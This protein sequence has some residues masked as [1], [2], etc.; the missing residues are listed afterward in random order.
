MGLQLLSRSLKF[1]IPAHLIIQLGLSLGR[2]YLALK[3]TDLFAIAIAVFTAQ[4]NPPT[5]RAKVTCHHWNSGSFILVGVGYIARAMEQL[6]RA[7]A[8]TFHRFFRKN[9]FIELLN[10]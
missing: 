9:R 8:W 7:A 2:I 5:S 3:R 4:N 1:K 6:R 10:Y